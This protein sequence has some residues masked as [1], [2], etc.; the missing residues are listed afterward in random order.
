VP[1]AVPAAAGTI[2]TDV[3]TLAAELRR[4]V[5]DPELATE[6]G[7]AARA[8]ALERYGLERFLADWDRLFEEVAS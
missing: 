6:R 1:E 7:L 2:S 5:G 3:R 8:A 4:L